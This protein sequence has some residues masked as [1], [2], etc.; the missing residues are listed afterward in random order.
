MNY[1]SKMTAVAKLNPY[2]SVDE[3]VNEL[4]PKLK[5]AIANM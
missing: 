3:I 1:H 2:K 5:L 4:V